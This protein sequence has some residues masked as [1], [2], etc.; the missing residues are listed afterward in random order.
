MWIFVSKWVKSTY[1]LWIAVGISGLVLAYFVHSL[2]ISAFPDLFLKLIDDPP[3][4]AILL[5]VILNF[6]ARMYNRSVVAPAKLFADFWQRLV[7]KLSAQVHR[8]LPW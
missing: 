3:Q 2:C 5:H 7:G 1:Y 6:F 8:N 4:L